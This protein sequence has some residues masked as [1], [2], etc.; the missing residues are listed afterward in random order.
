MKNQL[1]CNG[2]KQDSGIFNKM[3]Y[4]LFFFMFFLGGSFVAKS[5]HTLVDAKLQGEQWV[6]DSAEAQ[7]R[8]MSSQQAYT[9]RSVSLSEFYEK[10]HLY[11]V[12][13]E[14]EFLDEFRVVIGHPSW[15]KNAVVHINNMNELEFRIMPLEG[16][17]SGDFDAYPVI[18]LPSYTNMTLNNNR[19][20]MQFHYIYNEQGKHIEGI[21]TIYYKR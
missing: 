12:P 17:E 15:R 9:K 20:S 11:T 21:L 10:S 3:W 18:F 8:P 19:M 13:T 16:Y 4:M 14:I 2:K 1:T 7:E 5:Q 6:F